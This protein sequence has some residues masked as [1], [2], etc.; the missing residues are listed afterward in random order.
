MLIISGLS[1][2][3]AANWIAFILKYEIAAGTFHL[4]KKTSSSSNNSYAHQSFLS[5]GMSSVSLAVQTRKLVR[6]Y[7]YSSSMWSSNKDTRHWQSCV[8]VHKSLVPLERVL[9]ASS[10]IWVLSLFLTSQSLSRW[11]LHRWAL[12]PDFYHL[13][14]DQGEAIK[15]KKKKKSFLWSS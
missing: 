4:K 13:V 14:N 8:S 1:I 2:S 10:P 5:L 11:R 15:K 7:W 3:N 12:Q 9:V 6:I